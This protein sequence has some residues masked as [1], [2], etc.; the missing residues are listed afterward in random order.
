LVSIP[1]SLD[2]HESAPKNFLP[3]RDRLKVEERRRMPKRKRKE[4]G[5]KKERKSKGVYKNGKRFKAQIKIDGEKNTLAR[6][7]RL[8]RLLER[9]IVPPSEQESQQPN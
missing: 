8:M 5:S 2:S 3:E 7:T 9:T 1:T 4:D 6:S